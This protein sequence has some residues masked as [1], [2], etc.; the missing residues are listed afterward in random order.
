[1]ENIN[2][3][4]IVEYLNSIRKT[5]RQFVGQVTLQANRMM[6]DTGYAWTAALVASLNLYSNTCR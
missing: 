3:S 2:E 1:M 5:D 4:N 6:Q